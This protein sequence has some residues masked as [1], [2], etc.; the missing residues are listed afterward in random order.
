VQDGVRVRGRG[1]DDRQVSVVQAVRVP[2]PA[3][4]ELALE[5]REVDSARFEPHTD[6]VEE[7]ACSLRSPGGGGRGPTPLQLGRVHPSGSITRKG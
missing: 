7:H 1:D 6:A 3:A 2:G 5:P 4:D